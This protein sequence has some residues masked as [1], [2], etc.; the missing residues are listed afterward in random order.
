[1]TKDGTVGQTSAAT[2]YRTSFH[3]NI[4][5]ERKLQLLDVVHIRRQIS[6]TET[7][8]IAAAVSAG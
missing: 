3:S 5:T 2:Q 7:F 1:M 6:R 8:W 4:G